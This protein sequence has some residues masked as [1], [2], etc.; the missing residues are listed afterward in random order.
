[1]TQIRG[2]FNDF[3]L[4]YMVDEDQVVPELGD[5]CQPDLVG[6]KRFR[7]QEIAQV[8]RKIPKFLTEQNA[9]KELKGKPVNGDGQIFEDKGWLYF[10]LG[11]C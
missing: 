6:L 11:F 2:E 8:K 5:I 9:L 3:S 1:M 10:C 7:G 4:K